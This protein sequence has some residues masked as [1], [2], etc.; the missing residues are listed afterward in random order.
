[1]SN[2]AFQ[3]T[4]KSLRHGDIQPDP[5]QPRKHVSKAQD[6][7]LRKSMEAIGGLLQPI[8]VRKNPG[9]GAPYIIICGE[10]RWRRAGEL[11]WEN[12]DAMV[13][14]VE[15]NKVLFMQL[16]E[17]I[18]SENLSSEDL[19]AHLK[20]LVSKLQEENSDND[21][22]ATI[23]Q[24]A[25]MIGKSAGWV[26]EKLALTRLPPS[27]HELKTSNKMRDSR[28][29]ISLAKLHATNPAAAESII[30]KVKTDNKKVTVDV[31]NQV[32]GKTRKTS[33]S[34]KSKVELDEI[35]ESMRAQPASGADAAEPVV[36]TA[37][38]SPPAVG[39]ARKKKVRDVAKLIGVSSDQDTEALLEAFAEAYLKLKD[40]L[41]VAA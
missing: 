37:D 27:I 16:I 13:T 33:V 20:T 4:H 9:K 19:A 18:Q 24:I 36:K 14:D 17:N 15:L 26:S 22:K 40:E 23:A 8:L 1:M 25:Q 3:L 31:I 5:D 32:R 29:L 41:A 39:K 35:P 38:S 2:T 28:A 10:R 7:E 21:H 11:G 12:I 6:D 34:A 30:E